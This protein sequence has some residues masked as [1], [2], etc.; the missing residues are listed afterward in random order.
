[1]RGTGLD[2]EGLYQATVP[3]RVVAAFRQRLAS[4]M[5]LLRSVAQCCGLG[6]G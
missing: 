1:M 2:E 6:Q 4:G 5:L 3:A